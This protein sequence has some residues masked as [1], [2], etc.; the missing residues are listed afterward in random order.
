M[1]QTPARWTLA[2]R[3][4]GLGQEWDRRAGSLPVCH[5]PWSYNRNRTAPDRRQ[6]WKL[7]VSATVLSASEVYDRIEVFL[8]GCGVLFKVPRHLNFLHLL[9]TGLVGFSQIGKFV[10]IYP[11]SVQEATEI[12]REVH[13][14]TRGMP[15]PEVPF[16]LP[17]RGSGPVYFRYGVCSARS[18]ERKKTVQFLYDT[19][20]RPHLDQR[21]AGHA[22]PA[23]IANPFEA[24]RPGK[25]RRSHQTGPLGLDLLPF[26]TLSQRGKGGV[27][28]ALQ[29][30]PARARLCILKEGR[31]HGE[32]HWDGSDGC[33]RLKHEEH[34]LRR[35]GGA[36]VP[37]PKVL[38]AFTQA[39]N[40]YLA[41]EKLPGR[42]LLPR[43][44]QQPTPSWRR[45]ERVLDQLAELL[46]AIHATGWVWRDCKPANL[47]WHQGTLTAIDFEGAC[48]IE[49]TEVVPCGTPVYTPP[50]YRQ[51]F[52]RHAGVAE[53]IFAMGV[54][55]FQFATGT[56]PPDSPTRQRA[57]LRKSGC[58][59]K[60]AERIQEALA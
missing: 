31:R 53:D 22:V 34:L 13:A 39:G 17:Y 33:T 58:S 40:R 20:G 44:K 14:R 10:T 9:N 37:V 43:R 41:L 29:L 4:E 45:A 12:A 59:R 18:N 49:E 48:R 32:T 8:L 38:A 60:L 56:F 47:F 30:T 54:I 36:G 1:T 2:S 24:Q 52:S 55:G 23:W 15:G 19:A 6:G 7:H 27:Y 50:R 51:S 11:R 42:P 21:A 5:G 57:I 3:V 35:L 46:E 16:D 26:R 28:E 25:L